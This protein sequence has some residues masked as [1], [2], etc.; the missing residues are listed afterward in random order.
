MSIELSICIPTYNRAHLLE[1]SLHS[2][3]PQCADRPVEICISN[4][5]STDDTAAL[6]AR[7]PS[8]RHL[9]QASNIGIDR[10]ILAALNMATGKYV[11]PIGDDE[12]VTPYGI[13]GILEALRADPDML[14]LNGCHGADA[15]L[16][17]ALHHRRITDLR[18]AFKLL[19]D[20]MPL[21]G[22]IARREYAKPRYTDRYLGTHHAYSGAA[23]DYL[24]DI[25]S[26]RIDCMS[27]P[28]VDFRKAPKSYAADLDVIHLKEIPRWFDLIPSYYADVV[29]PAKRGYLRS[30][31]TPRALFRFGT[32]WL[33]RHA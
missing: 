14:M 2:L 15:H 31:R 17:A 13:H 22:F 16:P 33:N 5:A 23:W 18:E 10:N 1:Q 11:F 9:T 26:V 21:G 24:L 4:N 19:W 12:I 6:L 32:T 8:V 28:A 29:A 7:Y 25:G 27:E 3:L 30:C 20:K